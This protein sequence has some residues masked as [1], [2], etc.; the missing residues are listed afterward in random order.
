MVAYIHH[1]MGYFLLNFMDDFLGAEVED[2]VIEAYSALIRLFENVGIER[3]IKK[4]VLP[5]QTID[6]VGTLFD[7]E[8][9]VMGVKDERRLEVMQELNKWRFKQWT[10]RRQLESLIGKLQFMSNC[11][12]PRRLFVSR[13]LRDMRAM[14]RTRSYVLNVQAKKDIKWWFLFL[15]QF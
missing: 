7:A 14:K 5:V 3:S 11:I 1:S 9:M 10:T 15:S 6:F 12:R 13:L 2:K 4:L 8:K